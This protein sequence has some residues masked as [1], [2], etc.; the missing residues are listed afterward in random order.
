MS[1]FEVH[2]RCQLMRACSLHVDSD[3]TELLWHQPM[4][5]LGQAGSGTMAS[6]SSHSAEVASMAA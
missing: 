6:G 1:S 2:D 4:W 3:V 5:L